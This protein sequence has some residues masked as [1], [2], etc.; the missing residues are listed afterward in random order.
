MMTKNEEAI[1]NLRHE[2]HQ[3]PEL[4]MHETWTKKHLMD[5]IGENTD[6]TL[7]DRGAW[8]FAVKRAVDAADGPIA[9]RTDFDA[10]PIEEKLDVPYS[11]SCEGVSHKCGHDGHSAALCGVALEL[12][13]KEV[14]RDVY[15]IFQPGEEIGAGGEMCAKLIPEKQ[16]REVYAFHNLG[17]F[18][19]GAIVVR[20]GLTQPASKGL[21]IHFEGKSSHA[22]YPEQGHNPSYAIA[23]LVQY[24]RQQLEREH[25]GM[26]LGTIVNIAV[27]TKDFGVSAGSGEISITLRAEF[28]AEMDE[29]EEC[30][31]ERAKQEAAENS[32]TVDF[33]IADPFPETKNDKECIQK[34]RVAA[35]SFGYELIEMPELWRASED[36]GYY[37]KQCKGAMFYI[38]NGVNYPPLHTVE[39]DF[40]DE[41]L[42]VA[43]SMF[44]ELIA[45]KEM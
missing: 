7:E 32:L 20:E 6:L 22:S 3:Y 2:L 19:L 29:L 13:G 31:R 8:F 23:E 44:V 17:G 35:A 1:K 34:V 18:P 41:I 4:S 12:T 9:F 21:T 33:D 37:T 28:E 14:H 25:R 43:R 36:F 24:L 5:F 42:S 38:G 16:I 45:P 26:V 15:L 27:G 30:L 11:S 40:P 10:L 39:Y